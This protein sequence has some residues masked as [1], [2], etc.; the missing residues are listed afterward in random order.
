MVFFQISS[1]SPVFFFSFR[2]ASFVSVFLFQPL[3][4]GALEGTS[5]D[6]DRFHEALCE[7]YEMMGW[8]RDTGLPTPSTLAE[9]DIE[10]AAE[11]L[12]PVA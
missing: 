2:A 12:E 9:L 3:E 1:W 7:Y 4:K 6:R 10:W 8:D 11:H 5:I